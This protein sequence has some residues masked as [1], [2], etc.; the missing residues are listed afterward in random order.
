MRNKRIYEIAIEKNITVEMVMEELAK[1]GVI[2][3]DC[4]SMLTDEQMEV[5]IKTFGLVEEKETTIKTEAITKVENN[6]EK[7][8]KGMLIQSPDNLY[9]V[10]SKSF[11]ELKFNSSEVLTEEEMRSYIAIAGNGEI[12]EYMR[13]LLY[14]KEAEVPEI[15]HIINWINSKRVFLYTIDGVQ[16]VT[17]LPKN[18]EI[19]EGRVNAFSMKL[20]NLA[21]AWIDFKD[22]VEEDEKDYFNKFIYY[23]KSIVMDI[24][25]RFASKEFKAKYRSKFKGI[26]GVALTGNVGI[27][28]CMVPE[29]YADKHKIKAGD[30]ICA[31]RHPVQNIFVVLKVVGF[32]ENELR[33]HS[34]VFTWLGGDHDGD[35]LYFVPFNSLY[36]DNKRYFYKV[37]NYVELKQQVVALLPS[38]LLLKNQAKNLFN[39]VYDGR[40]GHRTISTLEMLRESKKSMTFAAP[41]CVEDYIDNQ[42]Q[43]VLNM[44]TVKDGTASAGAFCN[45]LMEVATLAH[46]D[47]EEAR[48]I[49]DIIQQAALD[50]KHNKSTGN[51]YTDA[52]WFKLVELRKKHK[53]IVA[54]VAQMLAILAGNEEQ[55]LEEDKEFEF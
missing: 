22:A 36:W 10:T 15:T 20:I 47:L 12:G 37:A 4:V 28:E 6:S 30:Y 32:T 51:G 24:L 8:E 18:R 50:S 2:V 9:G 29:W 38:Q 39:C 54:I 23:R 1:A 34:Q 3:T 25:K 35:K 33:I 26:T 43:T 16:Y 27:D 11:P 41:I 19:V 42:F 55:V 14:M 5:A 44:R 21:L 48:G 46:L 13:D 53:N 52:I 45:W 31:F 40:V 17:A 7:M 49:C